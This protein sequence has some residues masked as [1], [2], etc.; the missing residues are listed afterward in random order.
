MEKITSRRN[1]LCV[2]FKK[3]G[4]SRAYRYSCG[5]FLCD[6]MKLLKEAERGGAE[7]VAVLT[8][9]HIPF[10]LP[11]ETK[12][13]LTDESII[14]ALSPLKNAQSVLFTCR[15][16]KSYDTFDG[17]SMILL[18]GLQDP[19]N[20]GTIIRTAN[21]FGIGGVILSEGCADLYNPKTIRATMGAL[22]KQPSIMMNQSE[23]KRL[24]E[25]GIR[26]VGAS[27]GEGSKDITEV[28]LKDSII[29]IGSEG[30][31]ISGAI[32]ALCDEQIKIP[33]SPDCESLNAAVAAG[34]IMWCARTE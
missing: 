33:I 7:I 2:H 12:V 19:G 20:V 23:I 31:G 6:G 17:G 25:R 13:Y 14:H 1:P 10:P 16:P 11:I 8:S 5:E 26:F 9:N 24:K 4:M 3:L 15:I 18:D 32:L 30:A 22:F 27:V 21:A 28:R 34:V 29:V